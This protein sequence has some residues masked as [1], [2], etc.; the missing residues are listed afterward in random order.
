MRLRSTVLAGALFLAPILLQQVGVDLPLAPSDAH[1]QAA[2]DRAREL[3]IE[4][5]GSFDSG[6]FEDA[7]TAFLQAYALTRH[8]AVLLNLGQSEL[9]SG[10]IEEGGNH[11]QQFLRE[12]K[13]ATEDQKA[14]AKEGIADA[15]QRTGFVILIVDTDGADIGI[16]GQNVGKAPL[17]DP[18]FVKPEAHQAS[19]TFGG[20]TVRVDFTAKR[21]TATP[22][23][24]NLNAGGAV[25]VP[26]PPPVP[27]PS[28]P[29][30]PSP[31]PYQPVGP[32]PLPGPAL[33]G[34]DQ[35]SDG[36][37]G[38]F[39]WG[40]DEP[41]FWGG[42]ALAGANLILAVAFGIAAGNANS[43]AETVSQ[44]ILEE[45]DRKDNLPP[46]YFSTDGQPQPC[47]SLDDPDSA[48]EYYADACNRLRDNIDAYDTDI[49]LMA[50]GIVVGTLAAGGTVAYY[51]LDTDDASKNSGSITVAPML[52]PEHKGVGVLG[53]F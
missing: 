29:P 33:G 27:G 39:E 12:H 2:K 32:T 48:F 31:V 4:G 36:R 6:R 25:V 16:D 41:L 45:V 15:R 43:S 52:T 5:V 50:V 19:A 37:P 14:A 51:F 9:K 3:F 35:P 7:R 42:T 20:K 17:L 11:L 40:Y 13:T 46:Q 18:H 47:G 44:K 38:F 28:G 24:L 23:Q 34:P 8:P 1:A 10:H 30:V 49:A 26:V 21:G 53:T 22:V